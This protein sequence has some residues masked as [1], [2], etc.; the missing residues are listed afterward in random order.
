MYWAHSADSREHWEPLFVHS[1]D[2][3]RLA[4][5]FAE[6][7]GC[8]DEARAT[9]LLHDLA[10]ASD[11]FTQRLEGRA[12]GLDHWSLGAWIA[13]NHYQIQG[14][15]AALAIQGHHIGLQKAGHTFEK[16]PENLHPNALQK[17]PGLTL[18]EP[19]AELLLD[20]FHDMGLEFPMFSRSIL[21]LP[22][23]PLANMFAVRMLFSTLVDADFMATEAHFEGQAKGQRIYRPEGPSLEPE[24]ALEV[25]RDH[26]EALRREHTGKAAKS[27]L[28]LRRALG[29]ACLGAAKGATGLFTLTAPTGAGKTLA[30]LAFA[31]EHARIH[32]LRRI[33]MA[34]PYLSILE[35]TARTYRELFEPVFG[36]HYV[37]EHH[38]LAEPADDEPVDDHEAEIR[39]TRRQL[40]Q[41]WDAPLVVTTNV[42]LLESLF[43]N[44]PSRCRKLH[45]L[46]R[47]VLLFDE[48]QTLPTSLA[49][50]TLGGLSHLSTRFQSSIVF[51]TATQP[52]FDHLHG[53]VE[54]LA[55]QGWKP[56]EIVPAELG[57][58]ERLRR[59]RVRWRWQAPI[60]WDDL[61]AEILNRSN[62]QALVIVNLKRHARELT[63]ALQRLGA[64]GLLH[65]STNLCPAHR[66]KVLK[67]VHHRLGDGQPCLLISTQCVEAGVDLDF[68]VVYRAL[69]PLDA[70]AQAAGR[71]NRHGRQENLGELIVFLPEDECYPPGIYEQASQMTKVFL[72]LD[73]EP[74]L[75]SPQTFRD[76]YRQLYDL[77][78]NTAM[79]PEMAQALQEHDFPGV[80]KEYK[81]IPKST[82]QVVVPYDTEAY[83]ALRQSLERS[84]TLTADWI[85]RA[86][87]HTVGVYRPSQ[88][89]P[90]WGALVPWLD[91]ALPVARKSAASEQQDTDWFLYVDPQGYD[92][93][94]GLVGGENLWIA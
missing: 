64:D 31:L 93:Q 86:R 3:A 77:T 6:A 59:V 16:L 20:R 57:L 54:A 87:T 89:D 33:V 83:D 13:L 47:S 49:L 58:F 91:I 32:G 11:L 29:E 50:P 4:S 70:I 35:Q 73:S 92:P 74:D 36:P 17:R 75:Q 37:L 85:R 84:P 39:R 52:A 72:R 71:C 68:P 42:Q 5:T 62:E 45:R 41:N 12:K 63:K 53:R 90:I 18:T 23:K 48:A 14:A 8:Q 38:S 34:I 44:R 80:A 40:A 69:A 2:V 56:R 67:E 46:A 88:E 21:E 79:T 94:L 7:L 27:M 24:S 30:M 25:L 15:A 78:R 9:A 81:L 1:K 22:G 61:A 28:E 10:K 26:L 51:S 65:L 66:E 43:H 55:G 76:Y 60:S 82:I 19:N